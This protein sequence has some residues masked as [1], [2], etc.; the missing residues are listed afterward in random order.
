MDVAEKTDK[1]IAEGLRRDLAVPIAE[2]CRLIDQA[3]LD[4]ILVSFT[5][6]PDLFG[7]STSALNIVK[8]L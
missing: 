1:E 4:G 8:A 3:K 2:L 6:S 5:I 7:R